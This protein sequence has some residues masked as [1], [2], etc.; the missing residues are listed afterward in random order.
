MEEYSDSTNEPVEFDIVGICCEWSEMT[1]QDIARD[2]DVDLSECS[3][4]TE[5]LCEVVDYLAVNTTYI[6]L[7]D[8]FVFVQF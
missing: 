3:D 4:D 5:R 2:Y 7:S 8:S 1:W 6:E